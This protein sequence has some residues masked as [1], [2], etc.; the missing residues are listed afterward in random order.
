MSLIEINPDFKVLIKELRRIAVSLER[1]LIL[2]YGWRQEAVQP[3][4]LEGETADVSYATDEETMKREL[5]IAR[6]LVRDTIDDDVLNP[7]D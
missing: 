7:N 2:Q 5:D 3:K 6:G 4:E 1:L